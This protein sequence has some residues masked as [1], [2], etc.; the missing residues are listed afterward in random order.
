[1]IPISFLTL[2]PAS[3]LDS[4]P[5][6]PIFK[7]PNRVILGKF[8][9]DHGTP[10]HKILQWLPISYAEKQQSS[11]QP[12]RSFIT[13]PLISL[14]CHVPELCLI[15]EWETLP[16]SLCPNH[17][18]LLWPL[19][20]PG[21]SPCMGVCWLL[22]WKVFSWVSLPYLLRSLLD[23]TPVKLFL[24]TLLKITAPESLLLSLLFSTALLTTW[25]IFLLMLI[26]SPSKL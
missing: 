13:W 9:S 16:H 15:W 25:H 22:L 11:Q 20:A 26:V 23:V 21:R 4:P 10:L 18:G 14:Q 6:K 3:A 17:T 24:I 19:Q 2:L 12:I 5:S 7:R 8:E 1:M